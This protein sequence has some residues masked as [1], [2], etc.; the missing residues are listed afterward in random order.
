MKKIAR[1][2]V[3]G[4]GKVEENMAYVKIIRITRLHQKGSRS[5][6]QTFTLSW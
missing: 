5:R 4:E 1:R 3:V 6:S 2:V